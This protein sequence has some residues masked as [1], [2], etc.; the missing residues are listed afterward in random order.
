MASSNHDRLLQ[1]LES[2][3][4]SRD[5][6]P[7][8]RQRRHPRLSVRG[9]ALLVNADVGETHRQPVTVQLRDISR[10]GV[11]FLSD[12]CFTP[13][14][15]WRLCLLEHGH[16]IGQQTLVVRYSRQL[17][18]GVFL[19]GGQFCIESGLMIWLG[20]DPASLDDHRDAEEFEAPSEAA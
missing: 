3:E 11:G 1:T 19:V 14:T 12:I 5:G 4:Q 18:Q 6:S 8:S 15:V 7:A 2:L 10:G 13:N 17:D 9:E 20:V 16:L